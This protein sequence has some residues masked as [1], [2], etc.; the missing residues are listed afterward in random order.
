M[1]PTAD[2]YD[3]RDWRSAGGSLCQS[4]PL[5]GRLSFDIDLCGK[6]AVQ[7]ALP[8]KENHLVWSEV[9]SRLSLPSHKPNL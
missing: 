4:I 7:L 1:P 9:I 3:Q 8:L 6:D 5:Q 2:V